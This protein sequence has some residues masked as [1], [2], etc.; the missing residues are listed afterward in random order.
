M[1]TAQDNVFG[2]RF[3]QP[4]VSLANA[5][6]FTSPLGRAICFDTKV[7][8]GCEIVIRRTAEALIAR[9]KA[10]KILDSKTPEKVSS[11]AQAAGII[12]SLIA[13]GTITEGEALDQF[14]S[15]RRDYLLNV[16][17]AKKAK[18]DTVTAAYLTSSAGYRIKTF[19]TML[20]AGNLNLNGELAVNGQMVAGMAAEQSAVH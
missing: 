11:T 9:L 3:W 15:K 20:D 2:T 7:Q 10:D 12:R 17:A 19:S 5:S 8:G 4:A 1:R 14:L 18:G 16:A 13:G 6:G